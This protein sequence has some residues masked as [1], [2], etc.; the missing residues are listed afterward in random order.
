[1]DEPE[2]R[3]IDVALNDMDVGQVTDVLEG[4]FHRSAEING[5][6]LRAAIHCCEVGVAPHATACVHDHL[7]AEVVGLDRPYPIKELRLKV[8]MHLDEVQ[9]LPAKCIRSLL[10]RRIQN[11][12]KESRD[13]AADGIGAAAIGTGERARSDVMTRVHSVA[14]CERTVALRTPQEIEKPRLHAGWERLRHW[15]TT[16]QDRRLPCARSMT[17]SSQMSAAL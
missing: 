5:N 6:H 9:P 1:M 17:A 3:V 12:R 14:E 8:I 2:R 7:A 16:K 4:S 15:A 13:A 10:F 11:I